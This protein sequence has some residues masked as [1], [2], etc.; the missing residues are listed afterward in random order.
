MQ[1]MRS[2]EKCLL[3]DLA[4]RGI[5]PREQIYTEDCAGG[6]HEK[7]SLRGKG[8]ASGSR[9]YVIRLASYGHLNSEPSFLTRTQLPKSLSP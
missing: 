5:K 6:V 9:P 2:T 8:F 1:N 4:S 7:K 3:S